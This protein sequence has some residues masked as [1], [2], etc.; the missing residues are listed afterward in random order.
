MTR[1]RGLT[2]AGAALGGVLLAAVCIDARGSAVTPLRWA[3]AT[4]VVVLGARVEPSGLA[5]ETLATRVGHAVQ[6]L[7]GAPG[8]TLLLISGGVGT[9]GEAEATVGA[10]LARAAG[11]PA[12]RVVEERSSHS[13]HENALCSAKLLRELGVTGV[14]LVSDP[15]H[16]PR[17]RLEFERLGF[18]VQTSP[19]LEAPRHRRLASRVFWTLREV[20]ALLRALAR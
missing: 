7:R 5:S 1:I 15:S 13:T 16:L 3:P 4:A 10:R 18:A 9:Y 20:P 11:V 19:V 17:A 8:D 12:A 2:A 14:V 6:L